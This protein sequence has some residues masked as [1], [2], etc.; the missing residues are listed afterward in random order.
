M[1]RRFRSLKLWF[2]LRLFGQEGL[3]NHIRNQITLAKQFE[4][5]V[6]KDPRF[7]IVA[8]VSMAIVCFKMKV[9][10]LSRV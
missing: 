10:N 7:E 6:R 4:T 1:G 3:Q 9:P 2:T 8:P 5:F